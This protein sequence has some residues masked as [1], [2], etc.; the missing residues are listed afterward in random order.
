[1]AI[2]PAT[3][4][5]VREM[6][7]VGHRMWLETDHRRLLMSPGMVERNFRHMIDSQFAAV[8]DEGGVAG[9]ITGFVDVFWYSADPVAFL[10][11]W[12]VVPENRR[13]IAGGLMLRQFVRWAQRQE[14]RAMYAYTTAGVRQEASDAMLRRAGF[15]RIGGSYSRGV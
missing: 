8:L 10:Q 1:M 6:V 15:T 12:Y 5:D 2:R 9:V 14:V 4:D 13:G 3:H 11:M 7:D